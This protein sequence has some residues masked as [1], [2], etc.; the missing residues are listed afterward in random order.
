MAGTSPSNYL[1]M[2][3]SR[4]ESF[5]R[6]LADGHPLIGNWLTWIATTDP[7]RILLLLKAVIKLIKL[8]SGAFYDKQGR[9]RDPWWIKMLGFFGNNWARQIRS[10]AEECDKCIEA[11][12]I[13]VR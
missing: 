3:L 8:I 4:Y 12:N 6:Q 5:D 13:P 9:P 1:Q 10:R 11:L 2:K 7:Q